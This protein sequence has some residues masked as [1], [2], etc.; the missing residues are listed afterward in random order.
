MGYPCHLSTSSPCRLRR[1]VANSRD[2]IIYDAV[3]VHPVPCGQWH[4]P[5]CCKRMPENSSRNTRR[6]STSP[7]TP[8]SSNHP[9]ICRW[10]CPLYKP[11]TK[12]DTYLIPSALLL[13]GIPILFL[14]QRYKESVKY[15]SDKKKKVL[16]IKE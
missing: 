14:R 3:H 12:H 7:A 1:M 11:S 13:G 5:L 16:S 2:Y 10:G 9:L 6:C 4:P 15:A 8:Y